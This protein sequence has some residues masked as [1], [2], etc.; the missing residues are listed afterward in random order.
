MAA[1][2]RTR[3]KVVPARFHLAI[4]KIVAGVASP[5]MVARAIAVQTAPARVVI[6]IIQN[7]A[8][9]S[10]TKSRFSAVASLKPFPSTFHLR[11]TTHPQR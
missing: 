4:D 9:F 8:R 2:E 5:R 6:C 3:P 1:Y 11:L 10:L 7:S